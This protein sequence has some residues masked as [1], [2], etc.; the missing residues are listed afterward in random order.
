M[1]DK[2]I[3]IERRSF[4]KGAAIVAGSVAATNFMAGTVS[5]KTNQQLDKNKSYKASQLEIVTQE[6]VRP[7]ML[8]KHQQVAD[9]LPKIVKVRL[10]IEEKLIELEPGVK[11]WAMTFNGSVPGPM[12]VVHQDDYLELTLVNPESN[13]MMHNIDLHSATGALGAAG[14]THVNPGEEATVRFRCIKPGVFVYHCAPGDIMIPWHVVS[15]MNGAMMVLPREGLK[16][17]KGQPVKY[18]KAYYIGEQDFYLPKDA[19]GKYKEYGSPIAGFVD[20]VEIM[21]GLIPTHVVFNGAKG[22]VTGKN[23]MTANVGETVLFLHSQANR[24]T[25]PHMIG[26]H[27]D[28]VWERGSFNDTPMTNLETWFVP[29]GCAAA[30]LYTFRQPGIYVY[31]NHNLIEAISL[32]AAAHIQVEGEWDNDLMEQI[33]APH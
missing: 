15:G 8:P 20:T 16:D 30:A 19:N 4:F 32:G 10:V 27:G 31:L 25:R 6:M 14:L 33:S 13:S 28:L 3:D 11:T 21:K 24:D 17:E 22:A 5:A 7:P 2:K 9:G 18:D 29:G 26:G 12:I 23:A 1:S